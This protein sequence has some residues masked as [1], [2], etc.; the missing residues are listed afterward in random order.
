MIIK[1]LDSGSLFSPSSHLFIFSSPLFI[2]PF[3]YSFS[4]FFSSLFLF[5]VLFVILLLS[6]HLLFYCHFFY[7]LCSMIQWSSKSP[8]SLSHLL[9]Y[10]SLSSALLILSFSFIFSSISLVLFH[11]LFYFFHSSSCFSYLNYISLYLTSS[12]LWSFIYLSVM[13]SPLSYHDPISI[14]LFPQFSFLNFFHNSFSYPIT[15][16][17]YIF[18]PLYTALPSRTLL[19]HTSPLSSY[20]LILWYISSHILFFNLFTYR[21]GNVHDSCERRKSRVLRQYLYSPWSP[22]GWHHHRGE[23]C[24]QSLWG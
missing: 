12:C 19:S 15:S 23:R 5:I 13:S 20:L 10:F 18:S 3:C 22:S 4:S 2:T 1:S 17:S 9:F 16:I 6:S 14:T 21:S 24:L 11:L 8:I 7:L